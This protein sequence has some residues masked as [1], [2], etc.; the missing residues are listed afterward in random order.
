MA[1]RSSKRR[2]NG[3]GSIYQRKDGRWCAQ[4]PIG[5]D[6]KGRPQF[7]YLYAKTHA[8]VTIKIKKAMSDLQNGILC[9]GN[10]TVSEWLKTWLEDYMKAKIRATTYDSYAMFIRLH[11]NPYIGK[12]KLIDLTTNRIQKL[13]N[14][15]SKEGRVDGKGGLS[16]RSVERIHTILHKALQQAVAERKIPYNPSDATALPSRVQKEIRAL[17]LD[18][19]KRFEEALRKDRLGPA[20]MVSLYAGLRRGEILGLKW[21]DIDFNNNTLSVKRALLRE[22]D[23]DTGKS[24]LRLDLVK[25]KKSCRT[26]PIPEELVCCLKKHKATQAREKLKAG[27]MYQ[28][29]EMVFC[30]MLGTSI[31]PRNFN[32][33]FKR[34]IEIAEIEDF[35][36][37][38]LRHTYATRL[39]EMGIS[40]KII[41]EFM[42]HS[43]STTTDGYTHVLW[44]MMETTAGKM[45]DFMKQRKNPSSVEEG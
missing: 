3:E 21:K 27:A 12:V 5:Y 34:I 4:V 2:G 8:E 14:F 13:Y 31:E 25:T 23:K 42:G 18:E 17:T 38:G 20:F 43:Q 39:S 10:L 37:H 15:K 30:T 16:P 35:N 45:N 11:I 36:L 24:E 7:K 1:K 33:T 29:Q 19:Q 9:S 40:S 26:V 32:R 6:V 44:N 22:K 28:D 41:Q